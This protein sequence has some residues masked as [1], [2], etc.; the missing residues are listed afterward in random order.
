MSS[1]MFIGGDKGIVLGMKS[2]NSSKE[3]TYGAHTMSSFKKEEIKDEVQNGFSYWKNNS[4]QHS[5]VFFSFAFL[6][7]LLRIAL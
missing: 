2:F 5:T 4:R 3:G 7:L 6:F 1:F